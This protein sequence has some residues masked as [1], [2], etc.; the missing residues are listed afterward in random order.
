VQLIIE[1]ICVADACPLRIA[2]MQLVTSAA[3]AAEQVTKLAALLGATENPPRV[4]DAV[5]NT[6]IETSSKIARHW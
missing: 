1:V 3:V 5:L 4:M 6:G 2:V